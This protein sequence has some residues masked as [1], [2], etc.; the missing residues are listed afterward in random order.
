MC[1]VYLFLIIS[2]L[3][4]ST[5]PLGIHKPVHSWC[6]SQAQINEEGCMRKGI[7]C[8]TYAK[9]NMRVVNQISTLY[10]SRSGFTNDHWSCWPTG[11]RW[12]LCYCW[13]DWGEEWWDMSGGS[14]RRGRVENM[15]VG[16]RTLNVSTMTGNGR[17]LADMMERR[18]VDIQYCVRKKPGG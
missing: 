2:L 9:S 10:L 13:G 12:K 1:C 11:C 14:W 4:C 17:R 6:Q 7:Q 8:K 3:F 5:Q 16:V 15:N 18:K